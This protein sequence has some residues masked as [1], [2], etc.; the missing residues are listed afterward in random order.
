MVSKVCNFETSEL[1]LYKYNNNSNKKFCKFDS[2]APRKSEQ[3]AYSLIKNVQGLAFVNIH[4]QIC[5]KTKLKNL[6]RVAK[7]VLKQFIFKK[8]N[9]VRNIRGSYN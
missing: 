8:S 9:C 4:L 6:F 7:I 1:F 2:H 5:T 3:V